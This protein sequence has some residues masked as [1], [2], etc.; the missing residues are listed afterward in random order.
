MRWRYGL[1]TVVS[2]DQASRVAQLMEKS[3]QHRIIDVPYADV[4]TINNTLANTIRR[5]LDADE[6]SRRKS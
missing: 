3:G 2:L 4:R 6:S 1:F 5:F